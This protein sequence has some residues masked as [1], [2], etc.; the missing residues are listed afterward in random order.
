MQVLLSLESPLGI[1]V[2]QTS[3][4]SHH[5]SRARAFAT[6]TGLQ[7]WL[8][9][10]ANISVFTTIQ[11]SPAAMIAQRA[12]RLRVVWHFLQGPGSCPCPQSKSITK[13]VL[14]RKPKNGLSESMFLHTMAIVF[15]TRLHS[16]LLSTWAVRVRIVCL[17]GCGVFQQACVSTSRASSGSKT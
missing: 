13:D 4:A 10:N 17:A 11:R 3:P 7:H 14:F 1:Q 9:M 12:Y 15:F 16:F 2:P 6:H 5:C 8:H